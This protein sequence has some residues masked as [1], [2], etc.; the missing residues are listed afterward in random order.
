MTRKNLAYFA[1]SNSPGTSGNLTVSTAVDALHVTLGASDDGGVFSTRI[2]EAGVGSEIRS[3]CTY[4][5][6]TTTL[7][8]GTLESST[9]GSALNFTSAAK[10][11]V[12]SSAAD[13]TRLDTVALVQV[14]GSDAATTMAAGNLYVVNMSAWTADRTYTLPA[15]AAV[16]DRVG[17]MVTTGGDAYELLL[18]AGT[19]DTL[20]GVAGGT[21]WSRIFITGEI[22]VMRCVTANATWIVEHDGRIPQIGA[23]SLITTDIASSATGWVGVA[24]N[25]TDIERGCDVAATGSGAATITWRRESYALVSGSWQ[26]KSGSTCSDNEQ[27]GWGASY[28]GA[29]G[30]GTILYTV[31]PNH[32]GSSPRAVIG[33]GIG[34]VLIPAGSAIQ[35]SQYASS[36]ANLGAR[37]LSDSTFLR[38]AEI[39]K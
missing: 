13:Y 39:L 21:E 17:V 37:A 15:T 31:T 29:P 9:S 25:S 4:T 35:L 11:Q 1:I 38:V 36:T 2:F 14:T 23:F 5:H 22:V 10:V 33:S 27:I 7:T 24:C 19:E 12:V 8:R 30:V 32:A 3:G 26:G 16:G 28:G 18:T 6:G 20:N 34:R